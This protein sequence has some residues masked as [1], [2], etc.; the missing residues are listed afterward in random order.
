MNEKKRRYRQRRCKHCGRWYTPS[1]RVAARQRFCS[2]L[3][4]QRARR[5]ITARKWRK[6]NPLKHES[7]LARIQVWRQ[8]HPRYWRRHRRSWLLFEFLAPQAALRKTRFWVR[9][10]HEKSGA[11]RILK[12]VQ[13]P[14][15]L[16]VLKEL[17]AAL[18]ISLGNAPCPCYRAPRCHDCGLR[19]GPHGTDTR[20]AAGGKSR[21]RRTA[22]GS[23]RNPPRSS[24]PTSAG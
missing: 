23:S 21:K 9:L 5:R 11:L 17:L 14:G 22:A 24:R 1:P 13:R 16:C 3:E 19:R 20:N 10:T 4:C 7:D 15:R 2:R 18:R 12:L 8:N 6:E